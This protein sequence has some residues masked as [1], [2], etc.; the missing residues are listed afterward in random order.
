MKCPGKDIISFSSVCRIYKNICTDESLWKNKVVKEYPD[1]YLYALP[2]EITYKEIYLN[3]DNGSISKI[4]TIEIS[5][6][7][8]GVY[9]DMII[10]PSGFYVE[11]KMSKSCYYDENRYITGSLDNIVDDVDKK[12]ISK[13]WHLI[14]GYEYSMYNKETLYK[15]CYLLDTRS[16][17]SYHRSYKN[18]SLKVVPVDPKKILDILTLVVNKKKVYKYEWLKDRQ[19]VKDMIA[20]VKNIINHIP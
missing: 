13:Y 9:I 6:F 17:Y 8:N 10:L 4:L 12:F 15:V 3:M 1:Y 5:T 16:K 7:E 2:E 11:I 18:I 20:E 14:E 19:K